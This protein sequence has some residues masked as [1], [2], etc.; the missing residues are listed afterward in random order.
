M[1]ESADDQQQPDWAVFSDTQ[2]TDNDWFTT[3]Q[4]Q[5]PVGGHNEETNDFEEWQEFSSIKDLSNDV[6]T[7]ETRKMGVSRNN[8]D[9]SI[10]N[11]VEQVIKTC[12]PSPDETSTQSS[13]QLR[14]LDNQR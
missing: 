13:A 11:S 6:N 10:L 1:T 3:D 7:A 12:F 5:R 9:I 2:G 8:N 4:Q 14:D